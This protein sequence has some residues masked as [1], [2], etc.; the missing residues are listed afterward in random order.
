MSPQA[1]A[2]RASELLARLD[3]DILDQLET[4]DEYELA[5]VQITVGIAQVHASLGGIR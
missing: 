1:H 5:A 4:M 2:A 3:P